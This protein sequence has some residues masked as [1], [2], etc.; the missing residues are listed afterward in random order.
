MLDLRGFWI[1]FGCDACNFTPSPPAPLK[2]VPI[3]HLGSVSIPQIIKKEKRDKFIIWGS[4]KKEDSGDSDE[5]I[6]DFL[7]T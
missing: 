3:Q 1:K 7:R 5:I 6:G 2:R 4:E